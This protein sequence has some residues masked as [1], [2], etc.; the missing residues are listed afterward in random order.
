MADFTRMITELDERTDRQARLW[1]DQKKK[2]NGP[3]S[4][5]KG[6]LIFIN[7]YFLKKRCRQGVPGLFASVNEGM[8]E[9][10]TFAKFWELKRNSK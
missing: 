2:A 6:C 4:F 1:L 5:V 10:L 3:A 7:E 9:F 8:A